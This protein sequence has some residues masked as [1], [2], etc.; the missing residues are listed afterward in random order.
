VNDL[1]K[2]MFGKDAV[3]IVSMMPVDIEPGSIRALC[4]K[5]LN[6]YIAVV[7][8]GVDVKPLDWW[9]VNGAK[10]PTLTK[11]ARRW[12]AVMATSVPSERALSTAGNVLTMKRAALARGIARDLIFVAHNFKT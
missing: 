9:R 2:A 7:S 5:E 8:A 12:L 11:L 1:H 10:Y 6:D 4:T 3:P